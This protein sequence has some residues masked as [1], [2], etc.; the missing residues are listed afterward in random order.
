MKSIIVYKD[1]FTQH[2]SAKIIDGAQDE[3]TANSYLCEDQTL[4]AVHRIDTSIHIWA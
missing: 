3:Q 1:N 4:I 2:T